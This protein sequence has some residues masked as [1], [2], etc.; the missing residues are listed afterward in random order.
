M[1]M[2]FDLG[3]VVITANANHILNQVDVQF[4]LY[5]HAKGDWG[6]LP[7][8]DARMNEEALELGIATKII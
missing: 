2:K 1:K 4:A 6:Q 8:E 3:Q 7:E 5:R